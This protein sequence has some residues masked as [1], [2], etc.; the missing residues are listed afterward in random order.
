MT[1]NTFFLFKERLYLVFSVKIA[2][3]ML[4]ISNIRHQ[5]YFHLQKHLFSEIIVSLSSNNPLGI[6]PRYTSPIAHI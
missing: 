4:D 2:V 3:A 1:G 6:A 5:A